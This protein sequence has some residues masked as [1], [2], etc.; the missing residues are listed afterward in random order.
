MTRSVQGRFLA[1]V[2]LAIAAIVAPLFVLFLSLSTDQATQDL[3]R[4]LSVL[5]DAN[6]QALAKPL[7]DFDQESVEQI[8]ATIMS[9]GN[10]AS[11]TVRDVSGGIAINR[12]GKIVKDERNLTE[13]SRAI[14]YEAMEGPKLVGTVTIA[15]HRPDIWTSLR[16]ADFMLM[17]IFTFAVLGTVTTVL[18]A[19]RL[20]V[21]RPLL[22]L[23][24]AIEATRRL[25]SRHHVDWQSNDE[26]GQLARS[27]N[28]MQ[29]KLEKEE[30]DL[31]QAHKRS[32]DIY[33]LTPAMLFSLDD[34]D[35]ITGVSDYW[36]LASGYKR[37]EVIGRRFAELVPS[38][39]R[40]DYLAMR[41]ARLKEGVRETTTRFRCADATILDVLISETTRDARRE[42][43][44]LSL[45]VMTDVT[46]LKRSE[47]R[48]RQQ[49]ITD[50]LTGLINRQGFEAILDAQIRVADRDQTQLACLFVDLD[51]F[52]WINDNLG[53]Q[54]GDNVLRSFVDAMLPLLPEGAFAARLGG[55][56]FAIILPAADAEA[57]A[58]SLADAIADI[59]T[60]PMV[61]DGS[62]IRLSASIGIA[63]YP[64]HASTPAEL[65]QKSDMAM[66]GKKRD[67]KNGA[68]VYDQSMQED[69][70]RRADVERDIEEALTHDWID[71]YL[72]PIIDIRTA[73]TVG[74][75][76][77]MRILHPERGTI[78]PS[79]I[80]K[81][82][83]ETGAIN[84]L[85]GRVLEKALANLASLGEVT[86][87]HEAYLAVN[88]SPLQ[89]DPSLPVRLAALTNTHGIAP[90]RI[91][92]EIT[93]ATLLH[94]N[95]Q[96]RLI[97]DDFNAFGYRLALD[98]FGTGYSSLSYLNRFPVDIVKID[99]SF[100]RS[101]TDEDPDLRHKSRM[102]VE[103]IT[104][105]SHKMQCAVVAEGVE[106][107]EQCSVLRDFGV[108]YGQG[109]LFARP[110]PI[111][112]LINAAHQPPARRI[113]AGS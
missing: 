3:N 37:R 75:E 39:D 90:H 54:T 100:I 13:L 46:E 61:I 24:A 41:D 22:K 86:G 32:T 26:I 52:K 71:A 113:A 4:N 47:E 87:D 107:E 18:I 72:Q 60:E 50:H 14:F 63:V 27:F 68:L 112:T 104:T 73:R 35:R 64:V 97:L 74:Y 93:E 42:N 92:I 51:R 17:G 83:E 105:I 110:Q 56:E 31:R 25:G 1:I 30:G 40:Q 59:F 11:V 89:F 81:V 67:G 45:S 94:D 2:A 103:G 36:L 96:I 106:T 76:A 53:H 20:L 10:V 65:L 23:T 85:G 79:E 58:L 16:E 19:H 101:L 8:T 5:V 48:N 34:E 57:P 95:P 44:R 70:R 66:Y 29:L 62:T 15:Y 80:I 21:M 28:A 6:A 102:L 88:F 7:W 38:E 78:P 49:A 33:N 84:R 55:D 98:D 12:P 82:A 69:T 43:E 77:L 99:Q 108:D 91:V 111:Q 9:S 109:Y